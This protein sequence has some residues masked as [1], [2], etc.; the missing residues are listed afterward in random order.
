[1]TH[2]LLVRSFQAT[3]CL[4]ERGAFEAYPDGLVDVVETGGSVEG[5]FDSKGLMPAASSEE[6]G[7]RVLPAASMEAVNLSSE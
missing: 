3:D 4:L 2:K 1:M 5:L 7:D 6:D